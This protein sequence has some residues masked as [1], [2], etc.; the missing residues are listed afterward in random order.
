[1]KSE[2]IDEI[3]ERPKL[4]FAGFG[5][6]FA[7]YLID[8]IPLIF[9]SFIIFYLYVGPELFSEKNMRLT[10]GINTIRDI[11]LRVAVRYLSFILWIVYCAVMEASSYQATYGKRA[12]KIKVTDTRG[13]RLSVGQSILRNLTKIISYVVIG[14]GFLWVLFNKK[15]RG[16]HD[17]IANTYVI[18]TDNQ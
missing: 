9:I 12:M 3:I 5:I 17:M 14:L 6:R 18:K 4:N 11:P 15:R 2:I 10:T 8:I 16:W 7:A 1:M 13:N